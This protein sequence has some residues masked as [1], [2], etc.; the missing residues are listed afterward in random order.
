MCPLALLYTYTNKTEANT[1]HTVTVSGKQIKNGDWVCFKA[2]YETGGT[3]V[4][5]V[6]HGTSRECF[7]IRTYDDHGGDST[8]KVLVADCWAE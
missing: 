8:T 6:D 7:I 1:M 3:V 4:D 2:D 5:M